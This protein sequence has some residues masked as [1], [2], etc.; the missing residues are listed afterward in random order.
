MRFAECDDY[1]DAYDGL[2]FDIEYGLAAAFAAA[3]DDLGRPESM[4]LRDLDLASPDDPD[5][6]RETC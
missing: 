6:V 1:L 2:V 3:C 4:I 5:Y